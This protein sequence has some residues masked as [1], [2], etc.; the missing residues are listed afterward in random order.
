MEKK[1][2]KEREQIEASNMDKSN[3]QNQPVS[4]TATFPVTRSSP[5]TSSS[6]IITTADNV[7]CAPPSSSTSFHSG[8]DFNEEIFDTLITA[9]PQSYD[10][11]ALIDCIISSPSSGNRFDALALLDEDLES[12][13]EENNDK[14]DQIEKDHDNIGNYNENE[15][16]ATE[17]NSQ[18]LTTSQN[19]IQRTRYGR[20]LR[21]PSQFIPSSHNLTGDF[22]SK[23]TGGNTHPSRQ[24]QRN[25]RANRR[26]NRTV[27]SNQDAS[28]DTSAQATHHLT[29]VCPP[30]TFSTLIDNQDDNNNDLPEVDYHSDD[31]NLDVEEDEEKDEEKEEMNN[32][33][34]TARGSLSPDVFD[35]LLEFVGDLDFNFN[36]DIDVKTPLISIPMHQLGIICTLLPTNNNVRSK[37]EGRIRQC[38]KHVASQIRAN[39]NDGN[40]WKKYIFLQRALFGP[41]DKD[42][43]EWDINDRCR[44][45]LNDEWDKFTL[46][47]FKK[48]RSPI[49][50]DDID[51]NA[52][53]EKLENQHQKRKIK[54]SRTLLEAGEISRSYKALQSEFCL[55]RAPADLRDSYEQKL[56]TKIYSNLAHNT[57]TDEDKEIIFLPEEIAKVVRNTKKHVTNCPIT[58]NRYEVFKLLI[59]KCKTND[60]LTCLEDLTFV[61]SMIANGK[62]PQDVIPII[63]SSFGV[64]IPKRDNKD[65]P[66]GLLEGL[67]NLA[68]KCAIASV[69]NTLQPIF[70]KINFALAGPNKMSE[71]IAMSTNH[72]RATPDHD[73][74][75]VDISNAFNECHR[76]IAQDQIAQYCPQLL[77]LFNL[78]YGRHSNIFMRDNENNFNDPMIAMNGCVQG[79][80]MGPLVFGFATLPLYQELAQKLE[81]KENAYFGAYS[82]DSHI[83][84]KY[85]D[86]VSSFSYLQENIKDY[87]LRLNLG[88][89]KTTVL[90]GKCA[91]NEELQERVTTYRDVLHVDPA[92]IKIHPD[93]GGSEESYGYI[94]LGIPVGSDTFCTNAL[95][96]LVNQYIQS[97]ECDNEIES[98]QQKWVYLLRIIKQKF[99]FWLKHMC[100]SITTQ[101]LPR[102]DALLKA[103]MDNIDMQWKQTCLPIKSGGCGLGFVNDTITSAFVA[104]VEETINILKSTF[105]NA[106]YLEL[107]DL[108][109][110]IPANFSFPSVSAERAVQE[111]RNRKSLIVSAATNLNEVGTLAEAR[112]GLRISDDS[113]LVTKAAWRW[114]S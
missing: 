30:E 94:H 13:N 62:V 5:G 98:L 2:E 109:T 85:E 74:I 33:N 114:T 27:L 69:R 64:V 104:H 108:Q 1:Q 56:G 103:K 73:N 12:D 22:A 53:H 28:S 46:D 71:L 39:P 59:G 96:C 83:G 100:P 55:P 36:D 92:N 95:S 65:R 4:P 87:D 101:E 24:R 63:T 52:D 111:Y 42:V 49:T 54:R 37:W 112:V 76:G 16:I 43:V 82:D 50:P 86:A 17:E 66:L 15:E 61:L 93:N 81:N 7:L 113:G 57:P 75:F 89:N 32:V 40:I 25:R 35:E 21:Q 19:T 47:V 18:L 70:S 99:P 110:P 38:Y 80:C 3:S 60:E 78:F 8:E 68:I 77:N 79:C 106:P 97:A 91:S 34:N 72:L 107:F 9:I 20:T 90:I 23:D 29:T 26:N 31:L 84:A 51:I 41:I 44:Y 67:A 45:I 6:V 48:R 11:Q 88:P 58:S 105:T 14:G 102:L 10:S